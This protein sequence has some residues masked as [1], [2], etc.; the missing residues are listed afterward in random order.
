[1]LLR[2]AVDPLPSSRWR[3]AIGLAAVTV[4]VVGVHNVL[5]GVGIGELGT[6]VVNGALAA[7]LVGVAHRC[8]FSS[9]DLGTRIQRRSWPLV[10]TGAGV[11]AALVVVTAVAGAV[12][13]DAA[14]AA[15]SAGEV[16]SRL[17]IAI[18]VGT[19]LCEELIFRGVFLAAWDRVLRARWSTV[20]VSLLFGAWHLA[21]E[22]Q[23]TGL[24]GA[25]VVP[26]VVATAVASA[27][28]LCPLRRRSG[29][30]A[31]SVAVHGVTNIGAFAAVVLVS[32]AV[33]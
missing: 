15:L 2:P 11:T 27:V 21:A 4:V 25:T 30:L 26:G 9:R 3:V 12:P 28:V 13:A 22:A 16:L 14:V 18:P 23:R 6:L 17:L 31:A 7:G 8:G 29:D 19:A 32:R 33:I 1:M 20:V 24:F 10:A 5:V